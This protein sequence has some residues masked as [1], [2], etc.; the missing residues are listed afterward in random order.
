LL[1]Q[2]GLAK[3]LEQSEERIG[4]KAIEEIGEYVELEEKAHSAILLS[5]SYGVLREVADEEIVAEL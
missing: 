5:F 4:I 2:Q 1:R 3:V